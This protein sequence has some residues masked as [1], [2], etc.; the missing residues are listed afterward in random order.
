MGRLNLSD[1]RKP[2]DQC[3]LKNSPVTALSSLRPQ[4][5]L[6]RFGANSL[7][8]LL[9]QLQAIGLTGVI[10]KLIEI[11]GLKQTEKLKLAHAFSC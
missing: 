1:R 9:C 4:A 10:D 11:V 5:G 8:F 2:S 6:T 7:G 3:V